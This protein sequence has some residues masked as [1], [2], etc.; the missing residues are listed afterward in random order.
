MYDEDKIN[1][2][3]EFVE[4]IKLYNCFDPTNIS[5][6]YN[7]NDV[8]EDKRYYSV[9]EDNIPVVK[10]EGKKEKESLFADVLYI[11]LCGVISMIIALVFVNYVAHHSFKRAFWVLLPV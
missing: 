1:D 5:N 4:Q 10:E 2:S 3:L 11:V 6:L 7:G 9:D 8:S